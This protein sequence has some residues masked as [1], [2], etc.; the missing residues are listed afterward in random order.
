MCV[1]VRVCNCLLVLQIFG[2]D[3]RQEIQDG[4]RN[5]ALAFVGLAIAAGFA[6]FL[7]VSP[8]PPHHSRHFLPFYFRSICTKFFVS[9]KGNVWHPKFSVY[10]AQCKNAIKFPFSV[11]NSF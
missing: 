2:S 9:F 11:Y 10:R 8:L 7:A 4:V 1:C 5:Y 6:N 3:N